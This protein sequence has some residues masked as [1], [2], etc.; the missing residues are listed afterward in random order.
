M[1]ARDEELGMDTE[2]KRAYR[3]TYLPQYQIMEGAD[4][5]EGLRL[6]FVKQDLR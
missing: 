2:A 1:K 4:N 5:G 3:Q 6:D